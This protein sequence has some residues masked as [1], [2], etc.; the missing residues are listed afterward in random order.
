MPKLMPRDLVGCEPRMVSLY[1]DPIARDDSAH[2]LIIY[3]H[4]AGDNRGRQGR[5]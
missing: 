1:E 2:T 5:F 3:G 4:V